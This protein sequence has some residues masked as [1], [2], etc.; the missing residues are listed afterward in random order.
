MSKGIAWTLFW[1]FV[2]ISW[3]GSGLFLITAGLSP[4]REGGLCNWDPVGALL[5]ISLIPIQA[6]LAAY[7][8]SRYRSD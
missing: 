6:G 5:I 8:R 3:V 7:L 2:F 1:M 4:C